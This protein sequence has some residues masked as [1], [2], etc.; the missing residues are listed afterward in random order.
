MLNFKTFN[1]EFDLF[2]NKYKKFIFVYA[3]WFEHFIDAL[4]SFTV[5]FILW[6]EK[7]MPINYKYR[8]QIVVGLN[9]SIKLL[10]LIN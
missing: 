9:I 5:W 2:L 3:V 7:M 6:A 8:V 10:T 4:K 1:S